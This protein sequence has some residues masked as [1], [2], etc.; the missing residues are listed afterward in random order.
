M[1]KNAAAITSKLAEKQPNKL[2]Q[3]QLTNY[4]IEETRK[5]AQLTQSQELKEDSDLQDLVML[6]DS[7]F[8]WF[9]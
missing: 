4:S 5:K 2:Q 6:I 3:K 8:K 9:F 7:K 1:I